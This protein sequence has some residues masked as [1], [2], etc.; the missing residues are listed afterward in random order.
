[1]YWGKIG[2]VGE[3]NVTNR[4]GVRVNPTAK[5]QPATRV[6]WWIWEKNYS[7]EFSA[8]QE[9]ST[10]LLCFIR[11]Q[12]LWSH[13]SENVSKQMEDTSNSLL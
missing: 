3:Q 8:L 13:Q 9:S 7:S 2:L 10:M 5:L 11:L 4:L 6:R 12:V 1:L